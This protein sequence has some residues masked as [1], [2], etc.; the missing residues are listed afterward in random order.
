MAGDS[1]VS[2][3]CISG[4]TVPRWD[5]MRKDPGG[6]GTMST[7]SAEVSHGH[8]AD[9]LRD[10]VAGVAADVRPELD[11]RRGRV[12]RHV[13]RHDGGDDAAIGRPQVVALPPGCRHGGEYGIGAA[14]CIRRRG[15]LPRLDG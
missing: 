7:A 14:D 11:R 15:L 12:C 9:A 5:A 1:M 13:E 3:G 6:C 2:G 10:D 8:D 4:S